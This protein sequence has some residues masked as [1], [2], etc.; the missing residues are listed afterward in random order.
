MQ[1]QCQVP[2]RR[3]SR[4]LIMLDTLRGADER[5]I[6]GSIVF[7]LALGDHLVALGNQAGHTLAWFGARR[8]SEYLENVVQALDLRIGFVE[9]KIEQVLELS[10]PRRV[11]HF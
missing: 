5:K 2:G 6:G 4:D 7:L 8:N 1:L 11:G 3:V 9:V 10:R